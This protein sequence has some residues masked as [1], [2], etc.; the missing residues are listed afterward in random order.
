MSGEALDLVLKIAQLVAFI[1]GGG[2]VLWKMSRALALFEATTKAQSRDIVEI[3]E[4]MKLVA[5][6]TITLAR[7]DERLTSIITRM[8]LFEERLML[9]QKGEGFIL[10]LNPRP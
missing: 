8:N 5:Q 1:G 9:L 6:A 7:Q 2:I 4:E 10:P 3:R